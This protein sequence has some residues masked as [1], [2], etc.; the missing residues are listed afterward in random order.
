MIFVTSLALQT[1]KA[2]PGSMTQEYNL[3]GILERLSMDPHQSEMEVLLLGP[4]DLVG[5]IGKQIPAAVAKRHPDVCVIY[6]CTNDREAKAFPDAPHVK[7]VTGKV[8]QEHIQD[9]VREFYGAE[10]HARNQ[11]YVSKDD[12]V[13]S[14]GENPIPPKPVEAPVPAPVV[15]EAPVVEDFEV[16]PVEIPGPPETPPTPKAPTAEEMISSVKEV[17]DWDVLKRQIERDNI[18]RELIQENNEFAGISNMLDVWDLRI[19]DIWADNHKTNAEK[20]EAVKEFGANRQMLQATHNSVLVDKFISVMELIISNCVATVDERCE[21]INRAVS[22][23]R[24][25]REEYIAHYIA[26][27]DDLTTVLFDKTVELQN[28][29]GEMCKMFT[30]LDDKSENDI[31][32][33]LN[34][35]LPSTNEYINQV[36]S[37]SAK[38]FYPTNS[39][40]LANKVLDA[41]SSGQCKLS[42]M[43]DK[44]NA[45]MRT[46]FDVILRQGD[47][48]AYQEKVISLLRANHVEDIVVRDSL[49]KECF[50][51]FVGTEHSGLSSTVATYAG[52]L[53][54]RDNT[55]VVDL[56]EH[57]HYDRYGYS[58]VD[59]DEF[60]VDRKQKPL[61]VV[62]G[63]V[64][65][66]PERIF[67]LLEELKAR[68]TYY[69][70]I[71][72]VLDASQTMELEQLGREALTI[73]YVTNCT[74]E[75][76]EAVKAAYVEGRKLPNVGN[77]LVCI[78]SPV[79]VS[80]LVTDLDMDISMT[81]LVPLP[82]LPEMRKAAIVH[83]QPHTFDLVLRAFEEAF[84][85]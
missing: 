23:V 4:R 5:P 61:L 35:K 62:T 73:S 63:S 44:V 1:R 45:L 26:G 24:Q 79:N 14:L 78:D 75:S 32:G 33:R 41:L 6:F 31:I 52:M 80:T 72:L 36:L 50:N 17:K 25:H 16:P 43:E 51:I 84:R 40:S 85:V 42:L 18:I 39:D 67:H 55:L 57:P 7:R 2:Y 81:Q 58:T 20:L 59:L 66:D 49:L 56:T 54:R 38:L 48:I 70:H 74:P 12:S 37:E 69:R 77:K 76:M 9:A 8:K 27:G 29:L 15:Q 13:A 82:Y 46:I 30:F 47:R 28:I 11:A 60:L 22:S 34:E 64:N 71:I 68:L 19:R 10:V 83:Q 53:S 65:K 21:S 3:K